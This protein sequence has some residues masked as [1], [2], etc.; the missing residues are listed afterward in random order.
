MKTYPTTTHI[1]VADDIRQEQ[2]GKLTLVGVYSG[3]NIIFEL[4]ENAPANARPV[5]P[6]LSVYAAFLDGEGEYSARI[7]LLSPSDQI[8]VSA[9]PFP[10]KKSLDEN[11]ILNCRWAPV[12]FPQDGKYTIKVSLDDREFKYV[13][14]VKESSPSL[15]KP[16]EALEKEAAG[17][18]ATR[19]ARKVK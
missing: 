14:D 10:A 13:L 3:N 19:T 7:D 9:G 2:G 17:P 16:T 11:M 18:R 4:P 5:L 6:A 1:L 15:P 12:N 8:L